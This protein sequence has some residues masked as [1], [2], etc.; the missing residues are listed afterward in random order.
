FNSF[1]NNCNVSNFGNDFKWSKNDVR[2]NLLFD[3]D[4]SFNLP[5]S[6]D[7]PSIISICI[8][9]KVFKKIIQQIEFFQI[10]KCIIHLLHANNKTKKKW[11]HNLNLSVR[12]PDKVKVF[13]KKKNCKDRTSLFFVFC[14]L[15]SGNFINVEKMFALCKNHTNTHVKWICTSKERVMKQIVHHVKCHNDKCIS[16]QWKCHGWFDCEDHKDESYCTT[17][18]T[19]NIWNICA[20]IM[21]NH[22]YI[23]IYM[24]NHLNVNLQIQTDYWIFEHVC[25]NGKTCITLDH[26]CNGIKDCNDAS[27]E[28]LFVLFNIS[29][30]FTTISSGI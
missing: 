15:Q 10:I 1:S 19:K 11:K 28:C 12:I 24:Y 4:N 2:Y 13:T 30:S 16:K 23:H 14:I 26:I 18:N 27:D 20:M 22:I 9:E 8:L 25:D 21:V 5:S 29:C 6:P 7:T 3:S 17:C